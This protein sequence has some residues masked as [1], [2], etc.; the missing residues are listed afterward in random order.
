MF[1]IR[2]KLD[3]LYVFIHTTFKCV[4][5]VAFLRHLSNTF[6]YDLHFPVQAFCRKPSKHIQ[7]LQY[8]IQ[9]VNSADI[10]HRISAVCFGENKDAQP[11]IIEYPET[12]GRV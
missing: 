3:D 7:G 2:T 4:S 11:H 10:S 8:K 9:H 6:P 5:C 1:E 12:R